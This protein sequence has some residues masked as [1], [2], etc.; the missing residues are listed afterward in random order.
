MPV[1]PYVRGNLW[2]NFGGS[3]SVIFDHAD[4]I[5]TR[6]RSTSA[7]AGVGVVAKAASDVSFYLSADYSSNLDSNPLNGM[8]GN[9]G[10]RISW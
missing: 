3:D 2:C 6:H 10:V 4:T 9:M 8:A 7:D 1:E 5:K